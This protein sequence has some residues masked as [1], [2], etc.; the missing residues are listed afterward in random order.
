MP[1]FEKRPF[2]SWRRSAESEG[3]SHYQ[4]EK[5]A[6]KVQ[7]ESGGRTHCCRVSFWSESTFVREMNYKCFLLY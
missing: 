6:A 4:C 3:D 1:P 5:R 2:G 7:S